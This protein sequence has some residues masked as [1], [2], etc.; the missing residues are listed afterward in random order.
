MKT[1]DIE[2]IIFDFGGVIIDIDPMLT[3]NEFARLGARELDPDEIQDMINTLVRRFER[4]IFTPEIFRQRMMDYLQFKASAQEFDDAW[5]ALLFDIPKERVKVI[6][7]AK[8]NYQ[9]YL[10]SNSNEIHYDLYV[11]DLQ[12]RFGYTE[13][14]D[15]FEKAF[16][17]FD[18]HMTKPDLEIYEFVIYQNGLDPS[19]T[20][21]IDDTEENVLA[22]RK[23]GLQGYLLRKPERV[24]DLFNKGKLIEELKTDQ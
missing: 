12:L 11:R 8:K 4:G 2:T 13:F 9:I 7:K 24:R 1:A 14:D 21:F 10:L 22:A 17:S 6:E 19:K 5:N 18:L 15:L 3:M 23:L 16:F 20:L